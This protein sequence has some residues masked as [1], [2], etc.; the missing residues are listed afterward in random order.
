MKTM[1]GNLGVHVMQFPSGR[2]GFVGT[3]PIALADM[4][5]ATTGDVL[6]GRANRDATGALVA[7][8]FPVFDTEAAT[9]AHAASRGVAVAN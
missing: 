8:H 5:P 4:G 1:F 2:F 3:L 7:P 9:R 6:A